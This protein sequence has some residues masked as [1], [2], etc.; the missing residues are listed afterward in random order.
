M[1]KQL[2][3]VF[4]CVHLW[5]YSFSYAQQTQQ[6]PP[7]AVPSVKFTAQAQLVVETVSV[8]DKNGNT[9]SGLTAKDFVVTENGVPQEIRFCE[10]Q[11]LDNEP[12]P[13]V[14]PQA[15]TIAQVAEAAKTPPP[16]VT[17]TQIAA[18]APGD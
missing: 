12:A 4:L 18:E 3:S 14:S 8:K 1:K 13:P 7:A 15:A 17:Q 2:L 6:Q 10:F 5:P 11:K 9:I 16:P